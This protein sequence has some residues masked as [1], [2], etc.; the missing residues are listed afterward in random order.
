MVLAGCSCKISAPAEPPDEPAKGPAALSGRPISA[1]TGDGVVDRQPGVSVTAVGSWGS[2]RRPTGHP[3]ARR[4]SGSPEGPTGLGPTPLAPVRPF[5]SPTAPWRLRP[6]PHQPGTG[7]S[8]DSPKPACQPGAGRGCPATGRGCGIG[9]GLFGSCQTR[10]QTRPGRE[11]L[12]H[13]HLCP[14]P[15]LGSHGGAAGVCGVAGLAAG[16][17]PL[18][19]HPDSTGWL[20]LLPAGKPAGWPRHWRMAPAAWHG[21]APGVAG[22]HLGV[23]TE[24]DLCQRPAPQP[25]PRPRLRLRGGSPEPGPG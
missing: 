7:D 15:V 23:A 1:G 12:W 5:P 2:H 11:A 14:A 16:G 3:R 4:G 6:I 8:C 22:R 21:Q 18:P 24:R 20:W 13:W 10:R 17:W 25:A 19:P 9:G